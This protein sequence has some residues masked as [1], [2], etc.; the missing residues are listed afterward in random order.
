MKQGLRP[1]T[2]MSDTPV[3]HYAFDLETLGKKENAVILSIG[4][5]PFTFESNATFSELLDAGLYLKLSVEKQVQMGR[6]IEK[7]TVEFWKKQGDEAREVLTPTAKD[8][9]PIAACKIIDGF[10]KEN[11]VDKER[12]W[13]WSRGNAFDFGKIEDLYDSYGIPL[14][15]LGFMQ[16]DIRTMVD[17]FCGT[18]RGKV[19]AVRPQDGFIYHNALHDAASDVAK[20]IEIYDAMRNG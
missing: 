5:V 1:L 2:K 13:F 11:G 17:C 6:K 15:F 20:M 12:S 8:V 7:D 9:D 3:T 10:I 16:R 18:T 14:P 19:K 4:V